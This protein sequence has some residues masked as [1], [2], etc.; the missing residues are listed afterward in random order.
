MKIKRNQPCPCG[1]GKKH[2][3]CCL[4]KKNL[5]PPGDLKYR[6]LSKAY[7]DLEIKLEKFFHSQCGEEDIAAGLD[8]FFCWPENDESDYVQGAFE[9]LQDLYRPWLLY[10]WKYDEYAE[11]TEAILGNSVSLAY[12][13]KKNKRISDIERKL[14][15][16]I[17]T[18]SV[19]TISASSISA[20]TRC[21]HSLCA[22]NFHVISREHH[23]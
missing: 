8:E 11:E 17:F 22:H 6:R 5:V 14:I 18:L 10:D 20:F 21:I 1:S 16:G 3:K 4:N 13:E 19:F 7:K 15:L 23:S 2:K 9:Q 12:L